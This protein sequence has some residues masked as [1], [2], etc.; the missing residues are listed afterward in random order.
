VQQN[1]TPQ[2]KPS[3]ESPLLAGIIAG[4]LLAVLW[5]FLVWL[6]HDRIALA[7][8][9]IGGLIGVTLAK[10]SRKPNASLGIL[11]GG[12]TLGAVVLAKMLILAFLLPQIMRN[13]IL[14]DRQATTTMFMVDMRTQR[15]FSPELQAAID[16][17]AARDSQAAID[18]QVHDGP[19]TRPLGGFELSYRMMKE[20]GARAAAAGRAERERVVRMNTDSLLAHTGFFALLSGMFGI[21]DLTWLGLGMSTAWKLAIAGWVS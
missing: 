17:Q 1:P 12:V 3:D 4:I 16:S 21:W 2:A 11:A 18:S 10:S 8:W 13:E 6:T 5:A 20:A 14:R 9:G 15:S 7:A 19:D